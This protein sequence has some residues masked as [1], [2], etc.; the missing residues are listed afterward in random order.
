MKRI[1]TL[2]AA[3]LCLLSC[4]SIVLED[5]STCPSYL[6]F[7]ITNGARFNPYDQVYTTVQRH[8]AGGLLGSGT[9]S[10]GDIRDRVFYYEIRKTEAVRG[11]GVLGTDGCVMQKGSEWVVP[12]GQQF[13]PLFRFS[14]TAAVRSESFT[15]PVEMV[16]EY[17]QVT[18]QF[19]GAETFSAAGG[20]FPFEV[21]VTGGT[22]GVDALTGLPVRGPFEYRPAETTMGRF[23][24]R[25][26]RQGDH[27]LFLELYGKEGLHEQ[28]GHVSTFD[29]YTILEKDGGVSWEDRNLPDA[30]V[31]INFQEKSVNVS[32]SPWVTED[33]E[34]E[35]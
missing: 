11:Y 13:D 29:L 22:C 19:V 14:Y 16:K 32:V 3:S 26:P 9:A 30:Y 28:T 4:R 35:F 10:L 23:E 31:E 5:R 20:R 27:D 21:A 34:Y 33:L 12:I 7:D 2:A 1:L 17:A 15:V 8:P 18:V 6:F 25:L 24:F